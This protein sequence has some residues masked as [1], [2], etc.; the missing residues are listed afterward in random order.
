MDIYNRYRPNT[1]KDMYNTSPFIETADR[2]IQNTLNKKTSATLP[3]FMIFYSDFAG[4][5]K[6]TTGRIIAVLLNAGMDVTD[7]NRVFNGEQNYYFNEINAADYRKIADVR[8]LSKEIE[9][10]RDSM[11]SIN[12]V[13]MLNEAHQLTEEAQQAFLQTTENL[14]DNVFVIFTSTQLGSF[15][16][17]LRSRASKYEFKPL[18]QLEL[19]KL[20]KDIAEKE[21]KQNV[22]DAILDQIHNTCGFS[23]RESINT[24]GEYL[25][26]GKVVNVDTA[27]EVKDT[28]I[29]N[30]LLDKL[31]G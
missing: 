27:N 2:L 7:S 12:Y 9:F 21:S 11:L 17:K 28:T 24:L 18:D 30:T 29:F 8:L 1:F 13:Y 5:G 3:N 15:N 25:S 19:K 20:L 23:I 6:T 4:L 26:S 22:P 16:A 31:E 14:P 10:K